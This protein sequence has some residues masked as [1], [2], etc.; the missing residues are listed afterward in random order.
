M[1]IVVRRRSRSFVLAALRAL[2]LDLVLVD[3]LLAGS[4]AAASRVIWDGGVTG[5]WGWGL[6]HM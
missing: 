4:E 6:A 5:K 1:M 2:H 3:D